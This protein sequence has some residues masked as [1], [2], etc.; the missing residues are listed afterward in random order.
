MQQMKRIW[1]TSDIHFFHESIIKYCPL[2]RPFSSVEEMN[3]TIVCNWNN[4]V[5]PTDTVYILGDVSFG[6]VSVT[7]EIVNRLNGHKH[8]IIGNHDKKRV[9]NIEFTSCFNSIQDYFE[10]KYRGQFI[11]MSHYPM[12]FWNRCRYSSM[13]LHGH[14]HGNKTNLPG[15][16]KDVGMDTNFCVPYL[17]DDIIDE[18]SLI[19][20][21]I[22]HHK[23]IA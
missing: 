6:S 22:D 15:R 11:V 23:E 4:I 10:L 16:I 14:M 19:D 18:L 21:N 1:I 9:H 12:A 17:L 2:S 7:A 3:E 13:M 8:L 20:S 5:E